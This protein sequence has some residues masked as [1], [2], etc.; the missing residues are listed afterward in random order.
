MYSTCLFCHADL[1]RN[2]LIESFPVGRRLAFDGQRGRLWVVCRKCERWNLTPVDERWEAIE[3]AE[4]LYRGTRVR[5]A[6][7]Q[8]GLARF[9]D[10]EGPVELVRIGR[11]LR[12]EL[13][14]W[15]YGDQFGR[16]RRKHFVFLGASVAGAGALVVAGPVMGLL[17]LGVASPLINLVNVA[18][19]AYSSRKVVR[20]PLG[21]S[22]PPLTL[23]QRHLGT[24]RLL[25]D[26]D[27]WKL[28]V[29][30]LRESDPSWWKVDGGETEVTLR[31]MTAVR[32]AGA[33]LPPF[34]SGGGSA[35]RVREAVSLLE[36]HDSPEHLFASVARERD[37]HWK[38]D[39]WQFGEAGALKSIPVAARL[40]L[41]MAAHEDS[42]RR[43][44]EGELALLEA[45]WRDAEAIAKI[46]DELGK[47]D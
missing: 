15:R 35:R 40:A 2:T 38:R 37:Q 41:E 3:T 29:T 46:A 12:P 32:A 44:M 13:A 23:R 25:P 9:T 47:R 11:P 31:G 30:A 4:R 19:S 20:V 26:G 33:L 36:R 39:A 16:R 21:E 42:E 18:N 14:A 10:H 17:S 24:A 27:G 45:A 5:V 43:A 34:N 6:T 8:V 1:G 7:E 28:T 22:G